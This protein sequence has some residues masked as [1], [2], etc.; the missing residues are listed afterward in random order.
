ME[1][2]AASTSG[3]IDHKNQIAMKTSSIKFEPSR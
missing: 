3:T 1:G 2:V